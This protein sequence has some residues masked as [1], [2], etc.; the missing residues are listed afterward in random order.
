MASP[1]LTNRLAVGVNIEGGKHSLC[2][3]SLFVTICFSAN[4]V[5]TTSRDRS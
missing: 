4:E 3:R 2:S 5:L 1:L